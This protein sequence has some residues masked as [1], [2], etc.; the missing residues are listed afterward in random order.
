MARKQKSKDVNV[1][2]F[3]IMKAATEPQEPTKDQPKKNPAAVALGRLGG[4]KGGKARAAKLS[5]KKRK[6][7]AKKAALT[8]WG[9]T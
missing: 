6:E 3:E 7:I 1:T 5:A 9:A 2:A 8:R 4:L